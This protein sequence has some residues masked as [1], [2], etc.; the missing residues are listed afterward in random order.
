[1][2]YG[3]IHR[4][5]WALGEPVILS[6][7]GDTHNL[8]TRSIRHLEITALP[9]LNGAKHPAG[10]LPIHHGYSGESLSSCQLNDLPES[11]DVPAASKYSG[12]ILKMT[13]FIAA[14]EGRRSEVLSA[15]T[16]E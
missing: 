7:F 14:L 2:K 6:V 3:Q 12:E 10:K 16:L 4:R 11:R 5:S 13:G 1:M 9:V 15:N 8:G